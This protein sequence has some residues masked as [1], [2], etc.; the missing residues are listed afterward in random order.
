MTRSL[1][2]MHRYQTCSPPTPRHACQRDDVPGKQGEFHLARS[3]RPFTPDQGRIEQEPE[4][5]GQQET[6]QNHVVKENKDQ[7]AFGGEQGGHQQLGG[8]ASDD[9]GGGAASASASAFHVREF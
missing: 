2:S 1:Y 4:A 3:V 8:S 6:A 9:V 5:A 7:P